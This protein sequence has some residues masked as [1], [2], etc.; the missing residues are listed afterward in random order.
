MYHRLYSFL[1][2]VEFCSAFVDIKEDTY[3]LKNISEDVGETIRGRSPED[4]ILY[5]Q[6][7]ENTDKTA[8]GVGGDVQ[9]NIYK[10]EAYDDK[11]TEALVEFFLKNQKN[12]FDLENN[13]DVLSRMS[14]NYRIESEENAS[15][16]NP[17][18]HVII[19]DSGYSSNK[20]NIFSFQNKKLKK[21]IVKFYPSS[22]DKNLMEIQAL[23]K[24]ILCEAQ[25]I[26]LD[27][28]TSQH[29]N[30]KKMEFLNTFEDITHQDFP[31]KFD[32]HKYQ[33][34]NEAKEKFK[35]SDLLSSK[36][37]E[38]STIPSIEQEVLLGNTKLAFIGTEGLRSLLED[39]ETE[40]KK[41]I[42][43]LQLEVILSKLLRESKFTVYKPI[44]MSGTNEGLYAFESLNYL[45]SLETDQPANITGLYDTD[46]MESL[47]NTY[48]FE[49]D[50]S[51][52]FSDIS[53]VENELFSE[54]EQGSIEKTFVY[55]ISPSWDILGSEM[56]IGELDRTF[57]SCAPKRLD[58][59]Y[60]DYPMVTPYIKPLAGI[61]EMG[62]GSLQIT[63]S[64]ISN[65][66]PIVISRS[67][68][69]L[70]MQKGRK[71]FIEH[72]GLYTL[73]PKEILIG[74]EKNKKLSEPGIEKS[75]MKDRYTTN[76]GILNEHGPKNLKETHGIE[77]N[78][79]SSYDQ[80]NHEKKSVGETHNKSNNL[81]STDDKPVN[82]E[83]YQEAT[84]Y[85]SVNP[86][87]LEEYNKIAHTNNALA[88][89]DHR[90]KSTDSNYDW[91]LKEP[92][93]SAGTR[94]NNSKKLLGLSQSESTKD[95]IKNCTDFNDDCILDFQQ[96]FNL[97]V[98]TMSSPIYLVNDF[99]L[100]SFYYDVL[101]RYKDVHQINDIIEIFKS[102]CI[103]NSRNNTVDSMASKDII[104]HCINLSY[105]IFTLKAL[106]VSDL[107]NLT[108]LRAI[109]GFNLTWGVAKAWE[110]N[111]E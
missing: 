93:S 27:Y 36:D 42:T 98:F 58:A 78:M 104:D 49:N 87:V 35:S 106:N 73:L 34:S 57:N 66:Q 105:I 45:N 62:G 109:N 95:K 23:M 53:E 60:R 37:D 64:I 77:Q 8:V 56:D 61:I 84:D 4:A 85:D 47:K 13:R 11:G 111:N 74:N 108:V 76:F 97:V 18:S 20:L 65:G 92:D 28:K 1:S 46:M 75:P 63:F 88:S 25:T 39:S 54:M 33:Y 103:Q 67:F 26:L 17:H 32:E 15:S 22:L 5:D 83:K 101:H 100:L 41:N 24:N 3:S 70:G 51:Y 30:D 43:W 29:D 44:I 59:Y 102:V 110:I 6:N 80:G 10:K 2:L 9:E 19:I 99:Y 90:I 48:Q 55:P 21:S 96:T 68:D 71:Q 72:F 69:N 94:S 12:P 14:D 7:I 91:S 16:A 89:S 81:S 79:K 107:T 40:E 50:G 38:R 52:D 31:D 86:L 82:S